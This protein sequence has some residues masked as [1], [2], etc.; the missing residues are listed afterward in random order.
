MA[1]GEL[2]KA[3]LAKAMRLMRGGFRLDSDRE[4]DDF[5]IDLVGG[6]RLGFGF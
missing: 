5:L 3:V 4:I 1:Q 6:G 2:N